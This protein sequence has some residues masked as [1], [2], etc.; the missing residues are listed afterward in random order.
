MQRNKI[1]KVLSTPNL[2]L[3]ETVDSDKL[4][5]ALNNGWP[6]F[7]QN[8]KL[9]VMLQ[10]NTSQEEGIVII[11]MLYYVVKFLNLSS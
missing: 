3:I 11:Y 9:N 1:N 8:N 7:N 4:A 6:K 5:T 10:V 2:Y